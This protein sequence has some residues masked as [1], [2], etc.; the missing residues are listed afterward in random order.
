MKTLIK[1]TRT[2]RMVSLSLV[3]LGGVLLFLAPEGVLFGWIL[4][5]LGI[6]LELVGIT[7]GHHESP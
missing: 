5:L 2:R 4:L 3:A 1:N 6:G 7:L